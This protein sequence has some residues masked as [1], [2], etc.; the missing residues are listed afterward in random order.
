MSCPCPTVLI[1]DLL[2]IKMLQNLPGRIAWGRSLDVLVHP[3]FGERTAEARIPETYRE[4]PG[5]ANQMTIL[6]YLRICA[7]GLA[8]SFCHSENDPSYKAAPTPIF[9]KATTTTDPA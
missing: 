2:E 1:D 7:T 3:L 8:G 5:H 4:D 6:V 9:L